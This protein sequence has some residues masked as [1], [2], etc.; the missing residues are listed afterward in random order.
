MARGRGV[1]SD[2]PDSEPRGGHDQERC[3]RGRGVIP[4]L[5]PSPPPSG[6][7]GASSSIQPLVRPPLPPIPSS[8]SSFPGPAESTPVAQSPSAPASAEPRIEVS[9]VAG[10]IYPSF[11]AS[12]QIMR[13]IKLHLDKDGY[14][15]DAVQQEV[16]DFY[17]NEFQPASNGQ[18][19]VDELALYLDLVGG[20]KKRKV[21][22][23]GSQASQFYC[24][25]A[26]NAASAPPS[27]PQPI[28]VSR[29]LTTATSFDPST[30]TNLM[31]PSTTRH[32][33]TSFIPPPNTVYD[34]TDMLVA[35][36]DTVANPEDTTPDL[37]ATLLVPLQ[38]PPVPE[39]PTSPTSPTTPTA[40][41]ASLSDIQNLIEQLEAKMEARMNEALVAQRT[42][43]IAELGGGNGNGASAGG[44]GPST[45]NLGPAAEPIN[46]TLNLDGMPSGTASELEAQK[47]I[48]RETRIRGKVYQCPQDTRKNRGQ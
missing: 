39:T 1:D 41:M 9:L 3:M 46:P 16:R 32:Q 33:T 2:A 45:S 37:V 12:R 24:G 14:T 38:R 8:S 17:W 6:T 7:P 35:P 25:S 44:S 23:I 13:I 21:Y 31:V 48:R 42:A 26:S 22:G 5:S 36:P 40:P 4:P 11:R 18:S 27:Q 15:W 28:I 20:Q 47:M 10:H 29:R 34:T 19:S 30:V 43:L